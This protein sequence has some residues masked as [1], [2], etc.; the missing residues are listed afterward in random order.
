MALS[1]AG[2]APRDVTLV[3]VVPE[4]VGM[5]IGLSSAAR[6]AVPLAAAEVV[7]RLSALGHPPLPRAAGSAPS[8]WWEAAIAS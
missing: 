8:P 2:S 1:L 4:G 7:A 3:G 6:A 5:G